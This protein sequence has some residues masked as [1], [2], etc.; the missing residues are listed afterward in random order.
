MPA[1]TCTRTNCD[2][3]NY[4]GTPN[5]VHFAVWVSAKAGVV[6]AHNGNIAS[7]YDKQ[8]PPVDI[9]TELMVAP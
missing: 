4:L 5:E 6:K 8:L 3:T 2:V 7:L 1:G 9:T